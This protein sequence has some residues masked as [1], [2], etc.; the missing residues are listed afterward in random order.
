LSPH[1]TL[2]SILAD[3]AATNP[4]AQ[5]TEM[6]PIL[7]MIRQYLPIVMIVV[8]LFFVM[9]RSKRQQ[10]KKVQNMLENLKKG[11]RVLTKGGI[12]GNV[13][14]VRENEVVLKVDETS[15]AKMRFVR[16]AIVHVYSDDVKEPKKV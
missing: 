7:N 13:L 16:E 11:D 6:P 14:E 10:D 12:I 5:P 8:V 3:A 9:S 1:A 2:I 4:A 15:N